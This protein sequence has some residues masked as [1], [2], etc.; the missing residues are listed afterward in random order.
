MCTKPLPMPDHTT[1]AAAKIKDGGKGIHAKSVQFQ[2]IPDALGT[3][4]PGSIEPFIVI[5]TC[6]EIDESNRR[7]R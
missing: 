1:A 4:N 2:I 3:C 7:K 6:D 5:G